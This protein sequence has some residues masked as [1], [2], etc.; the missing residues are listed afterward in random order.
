VSLSG[1]S[2]NDN[3]AGRV[4][5]IIY[6]IFVLPESVYVVVLFIQLLH[7]ISYIVCSPEVV[8]YSVIPSVLLNIKWLPRIFFP[9]MFLVDNKVK[10]IR[11]EI[12]TLNTFRIG[13]R[14]S[15]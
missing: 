5:F 11:A 9:G 8:Q 3:N 6:K 10:L 1:V 14:T 15:S 13:G 12:P 7:G 2:L 4:S